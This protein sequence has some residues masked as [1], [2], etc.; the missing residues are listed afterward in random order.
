[1]EN[2][3]NRGTAFLQDETAGQNCAVSPVDEQRQLATELY[4]QGRFAEALAIL[5][6]GVK[7]YGA[8]PADLWNDLAVTAFACGQTKKAEDGFRRALAMN[9]DDGQAAANLG[10]LLVSTGR[11]REAIPFLSDAANRVNPTQRATINQLL[12][13]LHVQIA[14]DVLKNSQNEFCA[15]LTRSQQ[16]SEAN[17]PRNAERHWF[18][19]ITGWFTEAEALHLY[20][21]IRLTRPAKILE[22]GTFYGRST[23]TI[24]S[25]ITHFRHRV[26][27]VSCDLNFRSEKEFKTLFSVI[28]GAAEIEVP[29]ECCEA[30]ELGLSTL[31]Y[32]ERNLKKHSLNKFVTLQAGDFRT[33]TSDFDFVFA[34]VLHDE[35]EIRQNL[36]VIL[37]KI[38]PNGILAVHDLNDANKDLIATMARSAEFVS[39]AGTLGVYRVCASVF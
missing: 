4:S 13:T 9:S 24:C 10:V 5:E 30:F 25:A 23:A 22:I 38:R 2:S 7:E 15:F 18:P 39:Q 28:H 17:H 14:S 27:F 26:E 37:S 1:M 12:K 33:I 19:D 32:A 20:T 36:P 21:A 6:E 29:R 16:D 35:N 3:S 8:A 31:E 34:D 11:V